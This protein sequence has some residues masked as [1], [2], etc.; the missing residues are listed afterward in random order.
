MDIICSPWF[1]IPLI[2]VTSIASLI[3]GLKKNNF[4]SE[5]KS[6]E[7]YHF[8]CFVLLIIAP[9]IVGMVG[10]IIIL[11]LLG[12]V[13]YNLVLHHIFDILFGK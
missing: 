1:Y 4:R 8:I 5:F 11:V 12:K 13:A 6:K 3:Y 2:Y 7:S 10:I 9:Y